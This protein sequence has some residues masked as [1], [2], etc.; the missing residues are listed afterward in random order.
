MAVYHSEINIKSKG[1]NDI[2]DITRDVQRVVSESGLQEGICN[3]YVPGSTGTISTIEYE[4]GLIHDFPRIL[5]KIA[6]RNQEYLHHETWH[7]D[8]GR[9]HCKATLMGASLTIPFQDNNIIHGTWQ[10]IVFIELDT[11]SRNRNLTVQLVGE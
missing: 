11:G 7:D 6:P 9:S 2:I 5:E 10:Q 8:N 3:I 4:P 1:E